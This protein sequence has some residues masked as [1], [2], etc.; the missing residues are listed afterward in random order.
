MPNIDLS[1][2]FNRRNRGLWLDA[3]VFLVSL[4]LMRTV[5]RLSLD[6][7]TQAETDSFAKLAIGLFF[8]GLFFL[9][10]LGP[11]LKRWSFHDRDK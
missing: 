4:I 6:F 8:A 9:Q 10:P 11:L 7:V 1:A 3:L 5:T 2:I